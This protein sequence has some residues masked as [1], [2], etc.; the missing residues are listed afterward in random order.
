MD[1]EDPTEMQPGT[2]FLFPWLPE[3]S[4]LISRR[5]KVL[6]LLRGYWLLTSQFSPS[7]PS[8]ERLRS[9]SCQP[10]WPSTSNNKKKK[11]LPVESWLF[12][13][14][15]QPEVRQARGLFS[16]LWLCECGWVED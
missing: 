2:L 10:L 12:L 8:P 3:H 15:G 5:S 16:D 1:C 11:E 14:C 4:S 9:G 13:G 7:P 6:K